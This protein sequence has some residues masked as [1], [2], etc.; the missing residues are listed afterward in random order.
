MRRKVAL[1]AALVALAH[2]SKGSSTQPTTPAAPAPTPKVAAAEPTP[3]PAEPAPAAQE[4]K[5]EITE[6]L[7]AKYVVYL[8]EIVPARN[9]ALA[10]YGAEWAKIDKEKGLRQ[11]VD[12][13]K[14]GASLQKA[15]D[16]AEQ[17]S[18]AKAGLTGQEIEALSGAVGDVIMPRLIMKQNG[19]EG[20][21]AAMEAQMR[22]ALAKLP[23]D[24]R[25]EAAKQIQQATEGMK[26]LRENT[27]ARQKYG[28]KAVEAILK[29][30]AELIALQKQ[31]LGAEKK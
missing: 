1:L 22:E 29:H 14:T 10:E 8:K 30:E 20:Q 11:G 6:D 28:D 31:A 4:R 12:A 9:A 16:E 3:A 2:C 17:K 7:V 24:Q 25:E 15:I 19:N 26:N 23:P 13:L 18:R 5:A 21:F 27:E